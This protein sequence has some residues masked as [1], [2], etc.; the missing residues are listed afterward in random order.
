MCT[1]AALRGRCW[2]QRPRRSFIVT[3]TSTRHWPVAGTRA[4]APT[5]WLRILLACVRAHGFLYVEQ[6][7][8]HVCS[9][10]ACQCCVRVWVLVPVV[11]PPRPHPFLL[12]L[13][14]LLF[15]PPPARPMWCQ[16]PV[17]CCPVFVCLL[18]CRPL[19]QPSCRTLTHCGARVSRR[20]SYLRTTAAAVIRCARC[21]AVTSS[22]W[23]GCHPHPFP[24]STGN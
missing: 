22:G 8:A 1:W 23:T 11:F 15:L 12:L 14:L 9:V 21:P 17:P 10:C 3:T 2:G 19:G 7:H 6:L 5:R 18:P 20:P 24:S 16:P 13:L 4:P